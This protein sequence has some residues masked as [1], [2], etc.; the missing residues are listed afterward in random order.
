MV[1]PLKKVFE[2]HHL[3]KASD[4]SDDASVIDDSPGGEVGSAV[5][6]PAGSKCK[7]L[8]FTSAIDM[9]FTSGQVDIGVDLQVVV[10]PHK[11]R[12]LS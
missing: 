2:I 5:L 12:R 6:N 3:L 9:N 4:P 11:Q 10:L 8:C 1:Q 7:R